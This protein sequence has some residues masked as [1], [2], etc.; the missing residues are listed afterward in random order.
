M[1]NEM[2]EKT[3]AAIYESLKKINS[4]WV[5]GSDIMPNV[6]NPAGVREF[7][8]QIIFNTREIKNQE[9]TVPVS[10]AHGD[11]N[12]WVIQFVGRP[13]KVEFG[14]YKLVRWMPIPEPFH[15]E[16]LK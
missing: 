8:F 7:L 12:D 11:I 5:D 13:L 4:V 6:F 1:G 9:I 10:F 15:F 16:D 2:M 3:N 14:E